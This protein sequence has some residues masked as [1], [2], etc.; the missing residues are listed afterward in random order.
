[1]V[2]V[3]EQD[4]CKRAYFTETRV[5]LTESSWVESDVAF[6]P[7]FSIIANAV[8]KDYHLSLQVL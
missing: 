7:F 5:G 6:R 8:P 4:A 3:F 2:N 1:M